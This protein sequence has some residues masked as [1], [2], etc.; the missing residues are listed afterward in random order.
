MKGKLVKIKST[1]N[2]VRTSEIVGEYN[3]SP[4]VGQRFRMT[5]P[6]LDPTYY[7]RVVVTTPVQNSETVGNVTRFTTENSTYE[8]HEE[9]AAVS[10]LRKE[11]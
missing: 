2:N 4:A 6:P 9:E 5:A 10:P 1:H 7:T 8:L 11:V 3:E